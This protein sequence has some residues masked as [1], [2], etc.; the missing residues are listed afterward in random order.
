MPD[1]ERERRLRSKQKLDTRLEFI[2]S[3][4]GYGERSSSGRW[5][6]KPE[7]LRKWVRRDDS[8]NEIKREVGQGYREVRAIS[9]YMRFDPKIV[10]GVIVRDSGKELTVS[11]VEIIGRKRYMLVRTG[12]QE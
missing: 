7:T 11:S 12:A 6:S 3:G 10:P 1:L 9:Y 8:E 5:V 4:E 2:L